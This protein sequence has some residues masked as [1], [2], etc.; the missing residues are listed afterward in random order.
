MN[1]TSLASRRFYRAFYEWTLL[2]APA[3]LGPGTAAARGRGHAL[4]TTSR[5]A[6]GEPRSTIPQTD[7]RLKSKHES[8]DPDPDPDITS[9][10]SRLSR[11]RAAPGRE[12]VHPEDASSA[13]QVVTRWRAAQVQNASQ[14]PFHSLEP[15]EAVVRFRSDYGLM[16]EYAA[17]A[18]D[19]AMMQTKMGN[20]LTELGKRH[21]CSIDVTVL[22]AIA[23]VEGGEG[24]PVVSVQVSGTFAETA[25]AYLT[26][27]SYSCDS[28][29]GHGGSLAN[30]D[31]THLPVLSQETRPSSTLSP[32]ES[33]LRKRNAISTTME[34]SVLEDTFMKLVATSSISSFAAKYDVSIKIREPE[35]R[36]RAPGS[37]ETSIA[38]SFVIS[39]SYKKLRRAKDR[40]VGLLFNQNDEIGTSSQVAESKR[41]ASSSANRQSNTRSESIGDGNKAL[42][43]GD[44]S[45]GRPDFGQP[46]KGHVICHAQIIGDSSEKVRSLIVGPNGRGLNDHRSRIGVKYVHIPANVEGGLVTSGLPAELAKF[47]PF[48]QWKVDEACSVHNLTPH[49]LEFETSSLD[50]YCARSADCT[51]ED[52]RLHG[53]NSS[54]LWATMID[55]LPTGWQS[56]SNGPVHIHKGESRITLSGTTDARSYITA[57]LTTRLMILFKQRGYPKHRIIRSPGG[58]EAKARLVE[59]L[60][61]VL[62]TLTHPVVV[63]ASTQP[64]PRMTQDR[65][66]GVTVSSFNT[67]TL[68]PQP[69]VSFNLKLPS[70][71]WDAIKKSGIFRANVIA[72]TSRGA[73]IAQTFT[74]Q[75]DKPYKGFVELD[76]MG[77]ATTIKKN[78]PPKIR[79]PHGHGINASLTIELLLEKCI[80]VE[81]HVIVVGMVRRI[82][83]INSHSLALSYAMR[84]YRGVDG[85]IE[86]D[87]TR[88]IG[89]EEF[90]PQTNI[91][92]VA[93]RATTG[94]EVRREEEVDLFEQFNRPNDED[95]EA[96]QQETIADYGSTDEPREAQRR[97]EQQEE[98]E[99]DS[100][101]DKPDHANRN[102]SSDNPKDA[103]YPV[104]QS[105]FRSTHTLG[106]LSSTSKRPYSSFAPPAIACFGAPSHSRHYASM[107]AAQPVPV[108]N[109]SRVLDPLAAQST[110]SDYLSLPE[111]PHDQQGRYRPFIKQRSVRGAMKD[112]RDIVQLQDL[113][114]KCYRLSRDGD[115]IPLS[116]EEISNIKHN[117]VVLERKVCVTLAM[118]AMWHLKVMLDKA[119]YTEI[120]WKQVP[121]LEN[122]IEQGMATL[123]E[124]AKDLRRMAEEGRIA[125]ERY[126]YLS[127]RL[128][129]RYEA[130]EVETGRL[131]Q[132]TEE[133]ADGTVK[134]GDD[135]EW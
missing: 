31:G 25:A 1:R 45:K 34:L 78:G 74:K 29:T 109:L 37:S 96:P 80:E 24:V 62:R 133:E 68:Q 89:E 97:P 70:S 112:R 51:S 52:V 3:A 54:E 129:G 47:R 42:R 122:L 65:A 61:K 95:V 27:R 8:D 91:E 127:Q 60:R 38:R 135:E 87:Y 17:P 5:L 55:E 19:L 132:I 117:I 10:R 59:D 128:K 134:V 113:L 76:E 66:R 79:D 57:R 43:Q 120:F 7:G 123:M 9:A 56:T 12:Q 2:T 86:P 44:T 84:G 73:A 83:A 131:R 41:V 104:P 23:S 67:V 75:H 81:D 16:I 15:C 94:G 108:D 105:S 90:D 18:P 28:P 58:Q 48:L 124:D 11:P 125:K 6:D 110:V 40:I 33:V 30:E 88:I 53:P 119:R 115:E 103:A 116:A 64:G 49:K 82:D 98:D 39:G 69:I 13:D 14:K 121:V 107:S 101:F 111:D 85:P 118:N 77:L 35:L 114:K 26:L 72:G 46:A 130:M 99:D 106:L 50:E 32:N 20:R 63:V 36:P 100:D 93:A 21:G 22:S 4:H 126:E 71:S 102:S 92:D